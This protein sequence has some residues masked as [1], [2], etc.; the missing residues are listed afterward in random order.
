MVI[1]GDLDGR[2]PLEEQAEATVGLRRLSRIIVRGAGH[3][4]FEA[5]PRLWPLMADFFAGRQV[6][7][8]EITRPLDIVPARTRP[9]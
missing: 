4:I 2:T 6:A 7:S 5:E 3:D 1:S 9:T 8:Q